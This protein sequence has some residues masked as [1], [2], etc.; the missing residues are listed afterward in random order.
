MGGPEK[1]RFLNICNLA[2]GHR[3]IKLYRCITLYGAIKGYRL[4]EGYRRVELYIAIEGHRRPKLHDVIELHV[5]IE[6]LSGVVI[7]SRHFSLFCKMTGC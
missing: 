1:G 4:S 6:D 2:K 5:V 7:M 3:P